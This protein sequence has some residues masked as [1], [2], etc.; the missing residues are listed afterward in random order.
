MGYQAPFLT[1][2]NVRECLLVKS[3]IQKGKTCFLCIGIFENI[4]REEG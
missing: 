2:L 4:M 3:D 1:P